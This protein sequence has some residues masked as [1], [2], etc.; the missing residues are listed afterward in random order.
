MLNPLFVAELQSLWTSSPA[1][2]SPLATQLKERSPLAPPKV[3]VAQ[4]SYTVVWAD[5]L[6]MVDSMAPR[7]SYAEASTQL[8]GLTDESPGLEGDYMVAPYHEAQV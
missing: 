2:L 8:S 4:A 5:S 7:M 6:K 3:T 1:A